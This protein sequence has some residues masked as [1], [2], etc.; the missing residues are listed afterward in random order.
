MAS[1]ERLKHLAS[2]C[3]HRTQSE[4]V[5]S[6]SRRALKRREAGWGWPRAASV[7]EAR[8]VGA[9][10]EGAVEEGVAEDEEGADR[11]AQVSEGGQGDQRQGHA[12]EERARRRRE[13][14]QKRRKV[15]G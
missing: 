12:R 9:V 6:S 2:H 3:A 8:E 11:R 4:S 13:G 10:V 7:A 5:A 14:G 15:V 1:D